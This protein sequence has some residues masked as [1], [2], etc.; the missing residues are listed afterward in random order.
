MP[1]G[2][3]LRKAM[4]LCKSNIQIV[5]NT[6]GSLAAFVDGGDHQV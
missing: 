2:G 1:Y 3:R 6:F 5:K 4:P